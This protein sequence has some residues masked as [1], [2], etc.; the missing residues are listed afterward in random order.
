M[1]VSSK[2]SRSAVS[3]GDRSSRLAAAAGKAHLAAMARQGVGAPGEQQHR[4]VAQDQRQQHRRLHRRGL[5]VRAH[6]R[7]QIVI[8]MVD[9]V[10]AARSAARAQ[11]RQADRRETAPEY[12]SCSAPRAKE[13]RRRSTRPMPARH[14]RTASVDQIDNRP[15]APA[16]ASRPAAHMQIRNR[17]PFRHAR[18][19][20][21]AGP[22]ATR[23]R[24]W[25]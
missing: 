11:S 2:V 25:W 24:H 17:R 15:G 1:P 21:C 18:A 23:R 8:V 9:V 19:Q 10:A 16:C 20:R 5:R 12:G 22:A 13:R 4:F 14:P 7:M 6:S 3:T